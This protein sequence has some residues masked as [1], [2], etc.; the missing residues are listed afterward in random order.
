MKKR[1][2]L[3]LTLVL[4]VS[5]LSFAI[6]T[7]TYSSVNLYEQ[8]VM[9]TLWVQKS[10]EFRALSYQTFNLAKVRVQAD[11]ADESVKKPRTIVVDLDETILDNSQ[12][13]AWLIVHGLEHSSSTWNP[14]TQAG[15]APAMPGAVQFL[16]YCE[17]NEVEVFYISNRKVLDDNSGYTG[18]VKNLKALGFPNVDEEHVLFTT[19]SS[20]KTDRRTIAEDEKHVILYMGDNLNDFL[21]DFAKLGVDERVVMTDKYKDEFGSKFIVMP[22]PMYGEWE[23]AIYE[24]KLGASVAEKAQMRKDK[25][26]LWDFSVDKTKSKRLFYLLKNFF[27]LE[28]YASDNTK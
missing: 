10:A 19:D 8:N 27:M 20:N 21:N 25:L 11:L 13:Q 2:A 9:G 15:I 18:T 4:L 28:K 12:Y 26:E 22:N 6:M 1:F 3:L 7:V 23:S 5:L 17:A 16:K 14:W 24:Y